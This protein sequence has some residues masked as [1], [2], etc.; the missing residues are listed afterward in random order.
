[1]S[2]VSESVD[3]VSSAKSKI[4]ISREKK[5][6]SLAFFP[7]RSIFG[8]V[9]VNKKYIRKQ[10]ALRQIEDT[11][12]ALHDT[13]AEGRKLSPHSSAKC[14]GRKRRPGGRQDAEQSRAHEK[15]SREAAGAYKRIRPDRNA[16]RQG[17]IHLP[18]SARHAAE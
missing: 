14:R 7:R 17:R 13:P 1:L 18:E 8:E 9:K 10:A 3:E 12:F 4:R 15:G 6:S 5:A 2:A 16:V 11:R